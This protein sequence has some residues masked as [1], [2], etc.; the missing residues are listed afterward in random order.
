MLDHKNL[1]RVSAYLKSMALL[2]SVSE[3]IL[4][5]FSSEIERKMLQGFSFDD[6]FT[7]INNEFSQQEI[8]YVSNNK[9]HL[10]IM[11]K[12]KTWGLPFA[13]VA[14]LSIGLLQ[15]VSQTN[16]SWV[17]PIADEHNI[18][19]ASVFGFRTHPIYKTR[20]LHS[21]IDIVAE[22]GTPVNAVANGTVISVEYSEKGHGNA[23]LIEH[24]DG[25][26]TYYAQLQ[27][28]HVKECQKVNSTEVIGTVGSSGLST[29]PHL[30]F[31]L[32]ENGKKVN[33]EN[34]LSLKR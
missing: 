20:K 30:H 12:V 9:K 2:P 25:I 1:Q 8:T 21:G 11:G 22:A 10:E 15:S 7:S 24:E 26:Q 23:V 14:V 4:D 34:R 17:N 3:E 32:I 33:P 18:K 29:G 31:E 5:H 13:A 28:I 19:V 27:D 16:P 6:A